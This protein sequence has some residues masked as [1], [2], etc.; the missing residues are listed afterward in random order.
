MWHIQLGNIYMNI[1]S[2]ADLTVK[3]PTFITFPVKQYLKFVD[4]QGEFKENVIIK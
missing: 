2:I 1:A 3:M 4:V